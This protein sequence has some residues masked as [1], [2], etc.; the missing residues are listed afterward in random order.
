MGRDEN[1][2]VEGGVVRYEVKTICNNSWTVRDPGTFTYE[3]KEEGL[4]GYSV[5]DN[6]GVKCLL[7]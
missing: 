3:S 5:P 2:E 7:L 4:I 1:K 6:I